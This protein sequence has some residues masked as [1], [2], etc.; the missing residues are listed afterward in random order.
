MIDRAKKQPFVSIYTISYNQCDI[1]RLTLLSLFNQ[2]YSL[3]NYELIVLNDGSNDGTAEM[4][5]HIAQI[6]PVPL[7]ICSIPREDAYMSARRWNQC[8]ALS[9]S[10]TEIYIQ[11]DDVL[12]APDLIQQH[13]KWHID[14]VPTIVT[15]AK[16]EGD[17]ELWELASCR[18]SQLAGTG[19]EARET[20]FTAAWG[21]SLSF[22]KEM[23]LQLYAPP[24]D[25]PF[26]QR[27]HGWGYHEIE[28]ALRMV[29]A[30][31]RV[32]YDP[33]A[34]VFHKNHEPIEQSRNF[35]RRQIVVE[36]ETRNKLYLLNKHGLTSLPRW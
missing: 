8:I 23:M 27:M 36:G 6:A 19:G 5:D 3:D 10:Q 24:H 26:D 16:F 15:G 17:E 7:T 13:V 22:T 20:I 28:F 31:A 29:N 1:L 34:G 14:N 9:S 11:I 25:I 18:R 33:A 12:V 2:H 30:G 35:N 32:I 4:L 21:A